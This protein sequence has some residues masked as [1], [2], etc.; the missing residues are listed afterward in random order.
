MLQRDKAREV[1]VMLSA[2][3]K[4][5]AHE[6]LEAFRVVCGHLMGAGNVQSTKA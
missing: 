4:R 2:V 6:Y 1:E 3:S 5:R